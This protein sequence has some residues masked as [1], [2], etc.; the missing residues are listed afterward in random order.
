MDGVHKLNSVLVRKTNHGVHLDLS[1][2]IIYGTMIPA[3]CECIRQAVG[4]SIETYTS[5]NARRIHIY[6]KGIVKA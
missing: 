2:T 6:V 3:V 4:H 5:I 1:I